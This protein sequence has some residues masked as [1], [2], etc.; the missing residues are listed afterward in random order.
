L[1]LDNRKSFKSKNNI[2]LF[3]YWYIHLVFYI[4]V[5]FNIVTPFSGGE[6]PRSGGV[7]CTCPI[8]CG[9]CVYFDLQHVTRLGN[10]RKSMKTLKTRSRLNGYGFAFEV[11]RWSTVKPAK[12]RTKLMLSRISRNLDG[13]ISHHTFLICISWQLI[14][15]VGTQ[16]Q[17]KEQRAV[18]WHMENFCTKSIDHNQREEKSFGIKAAN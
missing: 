11:V 12:K 13:E 15:W 5:I 17:T 7:C 10:P 6:P 1:I 3:I 18:E 4:G 8:M 2:I 14:N 9:V 16:K